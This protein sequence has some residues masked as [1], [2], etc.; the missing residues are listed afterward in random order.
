MLLVAMLFAGCATKTAKNDQDDFTMLQIAGV[1]IHNGLAYAIQDV[2]I[3]VPASGDFVSCGAVLPESS[4]A[5]SFPLRDYRG[6][7]VQVI[8]KEH[9]QEFSTAEFRLTPPASS[10]PG[11]EAY[12]RVEVFA[13]GQA[14]AKLVLLQARAE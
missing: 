5:T 11:Q 4:C 3:K 2:I 12:I 9:G 8:W 6:N 14:G 13:E 10:K 7:K 1:E